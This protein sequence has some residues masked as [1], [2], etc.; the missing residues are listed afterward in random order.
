[1]PCNG[2]SIPRFTNAGTEILAGRDRTVVTDG[3]AGPQLFEARQV[4]GI[5]HKIC[6]YGDPQGPSPL[7]EPDTELPFPVDIRVEKAEIERI[8]R[9]VRELQGEACEIRTISGEA[10]GVAC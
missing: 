7:R 5:R 3:R 1:M 8:G 2:V 6:L 9:S 4:F 10:H